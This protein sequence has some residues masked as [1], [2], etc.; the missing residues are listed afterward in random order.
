M[1]LSLP[2]GRD[3][4]GQDG[5]ELEQSRMLSLPLFMLHIAVIQTS[6]VALC[7]CC[8]VAKLFPGEYNT[9]TLGS[10]LQRQL[11]P[12]TLSAAF[13]GTLCAQSAANVPVPTPAPVLLHRAVS[14]LAAAGW[15]G[16][17]R[18]CLSPRGGHRFGSCSYLPTC[19]H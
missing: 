11:S 13:P 1:T 4:V 7:E 16:G 9:L 10:L 18:I 19:F 2:Q 12:A 5:S 3:C 8:T 17:H 15:K 14:K 6:P